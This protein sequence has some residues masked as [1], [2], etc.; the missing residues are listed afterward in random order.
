MN[1]IKTDTLLAK[2]EQVQ[3][4]AEY[5][6]LRKLFA[7]GGYSLFSRFVELLRNELKKSEEL[8]MEQ[9]QEIIRK[10]RLALPEP[11]FI[12]PAWSSI[13]DDLERTAACKMEALRAIGPE[14]RTG[15]WQIII[16]NPY[17]HEPIICHPGLT[18]P[19]AAYYYG[20]FRLSLQKN[21]FIRLQRIEN[22][23]TSSG[24]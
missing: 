1:R 22:M 17:S 4:D 23:L 16:D 13:W 24:T 9:V 3:N 14:E 10:G 20:F 21:E 8:Q 15:E 12:S 11:G 6:E 18:F 7:E 5:A 19:E 2:L